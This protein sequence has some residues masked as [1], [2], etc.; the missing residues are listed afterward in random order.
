MHNDNISSLIL[1]FHQ[2]STHYFSCHA[3]MEAYAVATMR[4]LP[5][6]HPI[7]KLLRPHFRYTMA[8]NTAARAS[9]IN[10]GGIVDQLFAIGGT[11]KVELLNRVSKFY[12]VQWTNIVQH[13]KERGV[14]DHEKLPGYY[15]RDDGVKVWNAIKKFVEGIV[16]EFYSTD[17]EVKNDSE[18]QSWSEDVYTNAFPGSFAP[19]FE[20]SNDHGFPSE[21]TTKK[22]LAEYCTLIIFTGS[23]QH[24]SINFGQYDIYGFVPNA[25]ATLRQPPPSKKGDADY[26]RLLNTLPGIK[27]TTTQIAVANLLSQ[28]SHDE[29]GTII[30][31]V[32][33]VQ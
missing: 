32:L 20:K 27:D 31:G 2:L 15:Y 1:Q 16:D 18:V 19:D 29:V 7:L 12:K 11:G 10:K 22:E 26:N 23:A 21:L 13:A 5:D 6:S 17:E 3:A 14:D 24:A 30:A 9:L 25:P 33:A 28:Y 4:N 8:I